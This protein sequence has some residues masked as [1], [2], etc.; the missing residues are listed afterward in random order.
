MD[1]ENKIL[2]LVI[3]LILTIGIIPAIS[4]AEQI[5]SPKKQMDAGTAPE[6][7]VCKSGLALMIRNSGSAACME[8][9]SIEKLE[10]RGWNLLKEATIMEP[11]EIMLSPEEAKSIAEEAYIFGY[12]LVIMNI[13]LERLTN[14]PQAGELHAPINQFAHLPE[15]PD[16][17]F[18]EVVRANTDTLYSSAVLD[19]SQEPIILHI[20]DTQERYYLLPMLDVWTNVFASPGKRTTG[21]GANDFVITGPFWNG[22]LPEGVTEIK[23]PTESVWIIGR[24][25]TN[26]EEDY[27]FVHS[28]QQGYTLT[29]LS[30]FEKPYQPPQNVPVDPAIDMITP[31]V[32]QVD[33]LD[34]STFFNRMAMMMK[35]NPPALEDSAMVSKFEKIGLI[36]GQEFDLSNFEPEVI[37][38]IESGAISGRQKIESNI[39]NTGTFE[40]GWQKTVDTGSYGTDYL[41]RATVAL[42][43]L[44]ANIA[45]DAIYPTA[46]LDSDGNKLN[47]KNKYMVHFPEGQEPPVNGFWSLTMYGADYFF[48]KNPI[49][50]YTIGD[51][52]EFEYND[53]GSLD[54]YIQHKAPD[55]KESNWLPA[56][57]GDF[58]LTLRLYWPTQKILDGTWELP[59]IE[60]I[61]VE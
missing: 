38:A 54:I 58:S 16:A 29:P 26:G 2:F 50:R 34:A 39:A 35:T 53:N 56:P 1:L 22:T 9:D 15:F 60:K 14:V 47:G 31:P 52:S 48:V 6:D 13:T 17:D 11:T 18:K 37:E 61:A 19:L 55:R 21:T 33:L 32:E 49:N 8:P 5:D 12:P 4:F 23:S 41:F 57:D 36:P 20:S 46:F 7:V 51:R 30:S 28:I 45:E 43:G 59:L 44:G 40:N 27:D 42:I 25:Q 24:T 3:P 10:N